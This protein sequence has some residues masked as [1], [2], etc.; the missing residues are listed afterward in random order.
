MMEGV[1][2]PDFGV[3]QL[4]DGVLHGISQGHGGGGQ[5]MQAVALVSVHGG[6]SDQVAQSA[7]Q[8]GQ[9]WADWVKESQVAR[10][11]AGVMCRLRL[12]DDGT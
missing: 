1:E 7:S 5:A 3:V 2:P 10:V 8:G 6:L 4:D 9:A 12:R 11:K